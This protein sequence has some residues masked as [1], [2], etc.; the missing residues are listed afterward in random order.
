MS[1]VE[2]QLRVG[3]IGA[4]P[5]AH[6]VHAPG[7]T[8]HPGT[9][10]TS[11]WAR[12][13]E[14][15][16]ELA[17]QHGVAVAASPE[18]LLDEVDAVAFAV[19]PSV[20]AQ[21]AVQAAKAGKHL[22]LEKPLGGDVDQARRVAEA[23]GEA[24]VAALVMLTLHFAPETTDWLAELDRLGGWAGG[25]AKW[26]SG[27]LLGGPYSG[28]SWRHEQGALA[29]IGPHALDLLDSALGR[30]TEVIGAHH[31]GS[32]L[33]HLLL[34]HETGA[35]STASLSLRLPMR[36]TVVEFTVYGEH[37]H[38]A[39][40]GKNTPAQE[41]YTALLDDFVAMVHSGVRKHA[42]DAQRG[43]HLQLVL[44]QALRKIGQS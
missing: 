38:R 6:A 34:A 7:L 19:P 33:W 41:C 31:G 14:A 25:S 18:A 35:T 37:G 15:A 12:R 2:R 16:K 24:G 1:A 17:D 32:D 30:I 3:L 20:Q 29:D 8:D 39:L 9:L 36:P 10:L 13:P 21:Y 5:W 44:D 22:L 43:L 42:C 26:L 28:S 11:V 4:G 40:G 27:A 23:V